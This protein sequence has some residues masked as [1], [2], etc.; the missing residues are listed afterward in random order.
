M[1]FLLRFYNQ[2]LQKR[3]LLTK[4]ITS[5]CLMTVADGVAQK[6]ERANANEIVEKNGPDV[7]LQ[8]G[9]PRNVGFKPK[10]SQEEAN[11]KLLGHDF[12]RSMQ[13]GIVG[14]VFS[15]PLSHGWYSFL[16]KVVTFKAAMPRVAASM[17]L[18]ALL[19]TPVACA[20]YFAFRACLEN[21][22][23]QLKWKLE[24]KLPEAIQSSWSFWPIF[25]VI[26]FSLVPLQFRVLYNNFLSIIWQSYLS[27]LNNGRLAAVVEAREMNLDPL[28]FQDA[29]PEQ[30]CT[31]SHC[32]A[33][34]A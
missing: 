13:L 10:S 27:L 33:L 17:V 15:G 1:A 18:D 20:G 6:I 29:D 5:A 14:F 11:E 31:C 9:C 30:P 2:S 8:D 32:R 24:T 7:N 26:N 12:E 25:N 19:F 3:P 22:V 34:R 16:N 4:A 23:D 28:H 21:K